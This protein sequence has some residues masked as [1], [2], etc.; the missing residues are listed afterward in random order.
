[1]EEQ[2]SQTSQVEGGFCRPDSTM[3]MTAPAFM[4]AITFASEILGSSTKRGLL[5]MDVEVWKLGA[6]LCEESSVMK[7][8]ARSLIG[9][10]RGRTTG[11]SLATSSCRLRSGTSIRCT[12]SSVG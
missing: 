10:T 5:W 6:N 8:P 7:S 2:G 9:G 11:E 4:S 3:T 1:M 12:M